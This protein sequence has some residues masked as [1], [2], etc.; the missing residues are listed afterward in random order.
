MEGDFD[1]PD[2]PKSP[3]FP[4]EPDEDEEKPKRKPGKVR[5]V[6]RARKVKG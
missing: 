6:K 5:V 1:L 4:W 3:V 2:P